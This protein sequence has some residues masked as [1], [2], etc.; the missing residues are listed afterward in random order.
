MNGSTGLKT[1][2]TI[3][4]QRNVTNNTRLLFQSALL[5]QQVTNPTTASVTPSHRGR[6]RRAF[7]YLPISS[8]MFCR[9]DE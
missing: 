1:Q 2:L 8:W 5:P 3:G 4:L 9:G 6:R 7:I